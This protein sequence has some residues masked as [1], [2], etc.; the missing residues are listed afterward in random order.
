MIFWRYL[1]P[2]VWKNTWNLHST[3]P[4]N[5]RVKEGVSEEQEKQ[6]QKHKL[7]ENENTSYQHV[8]NTKAA[9]QGGEFTALNICSKE[10]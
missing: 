8:W 7:N 10:E 4:N 5:P 3:L 2:C 9:V 1:S 6:K